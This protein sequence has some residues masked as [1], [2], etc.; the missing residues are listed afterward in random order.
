[1][2]NNQISVVDRSL[3]ATIIRFE[4]I[5]KVAEYFATSE[6]FTKGFEN[7]DKDGNVILDENGKPKINIADVTLCLI[8]GNELGLDIAGSIMYGKK[9]NHLTYMSVIKGR[10]MGIDLATS[11]EK[12]IT[13]QGK[14][15][16]TSTYTMVNIITAKLNSNNVVFLPFIKNYAPFYIY[17]DVTGAELELDKIL[18]EQDDLKSEYFLVHAGLIKTDVEKAKTDGK[19]LVT[20]VQ[21]GY[22]TKAKFVRTYPDN[23]IVIHYQRFSSLDAERAELLPLW[24]DKLQKIQDGKDNWIKNT[25]QMMLNRVISIGGRIIGDDLLQGVYTREEIISAGIV[26]EKDAPVIDTNAEII[27]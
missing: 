22:Y 10:S 5:K 6:A 26:D 19:I 20:R 15:G 18:D 11:I 4:K 13:I 27:P 9:L 23:H 2:E 24:N 1:M 14:N 25:P 12:I 8:A 21:H 17:S 7:R 3:D 16:S